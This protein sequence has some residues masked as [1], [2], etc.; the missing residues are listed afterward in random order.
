[1]TA[2]APDTL[3]EHL[4]AFLN[5]D[6]YPH[7][8]ASVELIQTHISW[9][10]LTSTYAYKLKKP[11][12][13][14]FLDFTT[15][16]KRKYF[17]E[18]ELMLNRRLASD[19]YLEVLPV[20]QCNDSYALGE[21][22]QVIDYCLKMVQFDQSDLLDQ[23]L[24]AGTFDPAWM[25]MLAEDVAAFHA[26]AE[27]GPEIQAFGDIRFLRAHVEA[28]FQVADNHI[29]TALSTATLTAIRDHSHTLL[30]RHAGTIAER[31]RDH[32]RNCHGDLH[33]KNIMLF[34]ARPCIFDCI[35]FSDEYRM[36]DTMN[37]AA[38]L[39]MDCDVRDR[40]DLGYRFLSRYLEYTGDYD[41][42]KLL[43]L[44]LSYRACV[45]GKVACL[46][47]EDASLNAAARAEQLDEASHYFSLAEA[48]VMR[49]GPTLFAIGGFSGSGKSHL[50]L[51]GCGSEHAVI[52]R[53][54]ATRKRITIDHPE[55]P[56]YGR[57]MNERTYASMFEAATMALQA[58]FSVILDATFLRQED[59]NIARNI[60]AEQGVPCRLIWIDTD[61]AV[62]HERVSRRQ[63]SGSDISD[64]DVQVLERQ[65]AG[66]QRP[67][68]T[69][70]IFTPDSGGWPG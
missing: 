56:L 34:K 1:M 54:D 40:S 11:L 63:M 58:G 59:R 53:S 50:A 29:G 37:D 38:F 10:F 27:T 26:H 24:S 35:E 4:R 12:D 36:I 15:I 45:R 39:V 61:E 62:L 20:S 14:G 19:I 16:E 33:L 23:R 22:G 47:A 17:C 52:I 48:Y 68:E 21:A 43:P 67:A 31:Q 64:A 49:P 41:G 3:P 6:F 42:L 7:P 25:D 32:V 8:V 66:Y 2:T 44:Y 28:N 55:L 9:V 60:A 70:I 18:Q 69:D 30:K 46:L 51:Q 5:P 13:L 65:L 57:Q